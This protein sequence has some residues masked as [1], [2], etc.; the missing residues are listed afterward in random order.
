M[1][2]RILLALTFVAA[3]GAAS[4]A[5]SNQAW[6][7]GH[8]GY[9]GYGYRA[10]YYPATRRTT[11]TPRLRVSRTIPDRTRLPGVL[12]RRPSP[13]SPS[14]PRRHHALVWILAEKRHMNRGRRWMCY[15]P[16]AAVC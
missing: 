6:H 10:A 5:T 11:P 9:G 12:R 15:H 1:F 3:L 14:P 7:D 2:K 8:C 13:P 4:V 16:P